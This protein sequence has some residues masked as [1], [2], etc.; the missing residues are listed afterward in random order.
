MTRALRRHHVKRLKN[1]RCRDLHFAGIPLGA[2]VATPARCSCWMCGNPRRF[3]GNS[4]AALTVQQL[5]QAAAAAQN[6]ED[7]FLAA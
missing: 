7:F 1:K 6:E 3:Y 2:H 4:R 5:R